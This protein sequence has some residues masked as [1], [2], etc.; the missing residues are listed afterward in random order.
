MF[1]ICNVL[2][3]IKIIYSILSQINGSP[4]LII[5]SFA[6]SLQKNARW[7]GDVRAFQM[8]YHAICLQWRLQYVIETECMGVTKVEKV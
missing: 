7:H 6:D 5:A 3:S 4:Q 2:T 8:A 1:Q